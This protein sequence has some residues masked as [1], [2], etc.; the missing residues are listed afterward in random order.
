[1]FFKNT[2]PFSTC[3]FS[4]SFHS[5][6]GL[7]RAFYWEIEEGKNQFYD[8]IMPIQ[9]AFIGGGN[10][11]EFSSFSSLSQQFIRVFFF[12]VLSS[13]KLSEN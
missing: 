9:P 1:M 11:M 13:F 2:A 4:S 5:N 6:P 12:A 10:L 7:G 8:Q 3:R